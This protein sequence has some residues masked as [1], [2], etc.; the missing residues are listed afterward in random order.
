MVESDEPA[1]LV[2]AIAW[3]SQNKALL[4]QLGAAARTY[5]SGITYAA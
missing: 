5:E 3:L 1:A 2:S 4:D